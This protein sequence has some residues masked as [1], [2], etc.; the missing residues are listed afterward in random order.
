MTGDRLQ[1]VPQTVQILKLVL[2]VFFHFSRQD[3]DLDPPVLLAPF[4]YGVV[5]NRRVFT[6]A[7][8]RQPLR[9]HPAGIDQVIQDR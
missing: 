5:R 9:L 3:N 4:G 6:V 7:D 1:R 8:R 2:A